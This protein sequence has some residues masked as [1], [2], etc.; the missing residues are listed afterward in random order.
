MKK[1]SFREPPE[2]EARSPTSCAF[3]PC[4]CLI[5]I[6]ENSDI[7][8]DEQIGDPRP[9]SAPLIVGNNCDAIELAAVL[10]HE[11]DILPRDVYR[12]AHHVAPVEQ[13]IGRLMSI[14]F[15]KHLF[16]E[17]LVIGQG[18][19]KSTRLNSSHMSISYAVFCL[20]K[21]KKK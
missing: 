8:I 18:D 19:R 7:G 1:R 13:N 2:M 3:N 16:L 4:F 21:K 10:P 14:G 12:V 15:I 9:P 5:I 6:L 17:L 20:K 11:P